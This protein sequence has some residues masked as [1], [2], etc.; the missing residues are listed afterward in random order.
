MF[1]TDKSTWF[2][3]LGM[4]QELIISSQKQALSS[5]IQQLSPDD[6]R[7]LVTPLI[8]FT[9]IFQ[10]LL[11]NDTVHEKSHSESA[12]EFNSIL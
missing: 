3:Y 1:W 7:I 4:L 2:I 10:P 11:L 5:T 9:H 12:L 8:L 6:G